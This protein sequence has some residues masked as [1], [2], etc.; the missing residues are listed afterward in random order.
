MTYDQQQFSQPD[1][2]AA[3]NDV[4]IPEY[5]T[6]HLGTPTNSSAR[7]ITIK[8]IDYIKNVASSEIYPTWPTNSLIAN[9]HCIVTF[10][11]NRV[12]TEWYRSRGFNFDITNS[13]AYDQYFVEGRNIFETISNI[14]D[15]IFNVYARRFGFKNPYFTQYCNG[16]TSTCKGLSQWGTVDLAKAGKTPLEILHYYYPKDLELIATDNIQSIAASYP[17]VALRLGSNNE[18]VR[19]MQNFLN[20]IRINYPLIPAISNPDGYFGPDTDAAVR[21]FQRTFN[22]TADGVIGKDTWNK[23]LY[24]YVAVIRLAELDGEGIRIDIG[25][26]PPT[27]VL[28]Q[29]TS[30]E[31]VLQLQFILDAVAPYY[32]LP[33]VVKEGKFGATTKNAVIEFQKAFKLTA[34]GVVGAST[35]NKLYSVYRGVAETAPAPPAEVVPPSGAPKYPGTALRLGSTGTDVRTMQSYLNAIRTVY[36]N[37]PQLTVDGSYGPATEAAV[38]AFQRQ[39]LLSPDGVI[40]AVTWDKIVQTY[41]EV[42]GSAGIS[43]EYPGYLMK[44]GSTGESVKLMQ[45][46]LNR[47]AS[48]YTTL[49]RISADGI[50]GNQTLQAVTAF[51][52]MFGLSADGIIGPSTWNAIVARN[53]E[54]FG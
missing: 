14:T 21:A 36:G 42:S 3:Y 1:T 48:V 38:V 22:M 13:T 50:F 54:Y 40:G 24:I 7:N 51:Q 43:A 32:D 35:W 2:R 16:T 5:I 9:I 4:F 10:A 26:T 33:P 49:P 34:D 27:K 6:V 11:I 25:K 18:N 17:G 44:L 23:I 29:G 47:L 39:M 31:D 19:I 53:N 20:R 15:S 37:I 41:S 28:S 8:F 45:T 12:Y 30:G 52:K 46:F